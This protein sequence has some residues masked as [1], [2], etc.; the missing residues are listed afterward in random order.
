MATI[1]GTAGNNILSADGANSA[2]GLGGNDR[3]TQYQFGYHAGDKVLLDGGSGNDF[4]VSFLSNTSDATVPNATTTV[5]V[6]GGDGNDTIQVMGA[7]A[8]TVDAGNGN[9][10]VLVGV[11]GYPTDHFVTGAKG[12][13]ITL[14]A[15]ADTLAI[16]S[17]DYAGAASIITDFNPAEDRITFDELMVFG[18]GLG[19][20]NLGNPFTN[21]YL[22]LIKSGADTKLQIDRDGGGNG[23][24]DAIVFRNLAPSAFTEIAG[25]SLSGSTVHDH[26][27]TSVSAGLFTFGDRLQA[28][29]RGGAGNDTL[30]GT[31]YADFLSGG[32]GN[33]VIIGGGGKDVLQ[34]NFGKNVLR[35][36]S[37]NDEI[38]S[39]GSDDQQFGD[40]GNDVLTYSSLSRANLQGGL[41]RMDGGAG[42]DQLVVET[43]TAQARLI[44]GS[45]N[46][47]ITISEGMVGASIIN[48]GS[49]D[50]TITVTNGFS[51]IT[52]GTGSDSVTIA[53]DYYTPA[54]QHI[55]LTDYLPGTDSVGFSLADYLGQ[56]DGA[57][58]PFD[59]G[60]LGMRQDGSDTV[61]LIDASGG[62]DQL[63]ELIRFKGLS[64]AQLTAPDTAGFTF[65]AADFVGKAGNDT[66]T[67]LSGSDTMNGYGGAD[68]L[69]GLGGDDRI[70]GGA[71]DDTLNGGNGRDTLVGGAGR[72][73]LTGGSGADQFV[74][75]GNETGASATTADTVTDFSHAEQ[76][77]IDLSAIDASRAATGNQAFAFIGTADFSAA[78]QLRY[79]Q[80]GGN[81]FIEGDVNGDGKADFMIRLD[82]L[83]T[84]V[85]GDFVL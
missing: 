53:R 85:A 30:T 55:T 77:R 3:I 62:G 51:T 43:T 8:R 80:T 66:F 42:G 68:T 14:G 75:S 65:G 78:G 39:H 26:A 11:D 44:G 33:D 69:S 36:G 24:V 73:I 76:D 61:L 52:L 37:G 15:G 23:F 72:D 1:T 13:T 74:F 79:A 83:H 58:N 50:D 49:G 40:D 18:T 71:G 81:T 67:G 38:T 82:G 46:D 20:P 57:S 47:T 9:D 27:I 6:R 19:V 25:F 29:T 5:T 54:N 63:I 84:L 17:F 32:Y 10:V 4:I 12:S 60:F 34:D 21:G 35:G 16:N 28:I 48:G 59:T 64:L 70:A 56:W 2:Q 7:I 22:R 31:A 45:G 41:I